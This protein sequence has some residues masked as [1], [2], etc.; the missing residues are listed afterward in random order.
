MSSPN[1]GQNYR[2]QQELSHPNPD[3]NGGA[4]VDMEEDGVDRNEPLVGEK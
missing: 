3:G 1:K 2:I 4:D